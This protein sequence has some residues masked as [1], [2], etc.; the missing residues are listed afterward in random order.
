MRRSIF[1]VPLFGPYQVSNWSS[2]LKSDLLT[3]FKKTKPKDRGCVLTDY[4]D[5][6]NL[7]GYKKFVIDTLGQV[8]NEFSQDIQIPTDKMYVPDIWIETSRK[9]GHHNLHTHGAVGYSA[10]F[11]IEFDPEA[12]KSTV[13]YS[14]LHNFINGEC[15]YFQDTGTQEGS[16]V[17]FPSCLMHEAPCNS[18][19]KPRTVCSFNIKFR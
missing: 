4:N 3:R 14:P 6:L 16:V 19:E 9:H 13:F 5:S 17:F 12:H 1:E 8:F 11:Y 10:C 2:D 18:V 7:P 15:L